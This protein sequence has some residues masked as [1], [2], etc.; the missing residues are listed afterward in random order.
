MNVL[1]RRLHRSTAHHRRRRGFTLSE[2]L[3]ASAVFGLAITMATKF[4]ID[5]LGLYHLTAGKLMVNRD[6]RK[7]TA[8]M[9]DEARNADD[10]Q[11]FASYTNRTV[12][13]DGV[14]GDYLVLRFRNPNGA[15]VRTVGYYRAPA[16]PLDP[17]SLG[18]VRKHD[19]AAPGYTGN[20]I[21]LPPVTAISTFPEVIEL[22][23]G[24]S[25]GKLFYNFYDRSVMIRG[26]LIHPGNLRKRATNTYN[27]TVSPRG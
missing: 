3:V 9:T 12:V 13:N 6:V 10:F 1:S 20:A 11:I 26:E 27:F 16:D 24:L 18:P 2:V 25:N 5:G 23:R 15:I 4:F 8:A 7:F 14:S 21:D 19:S 17:D 22:S